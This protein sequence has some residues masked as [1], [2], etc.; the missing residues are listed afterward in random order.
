MNKPIRALHSIHLYINKWREKKGNLNA[1]MTTRRSTTP[2]S[3]IQNHSPM[4]ENGCN[5]FYSVNPACGKTLVRTTLRKCRYSRFPVKVF[6]FFF[7]FFQGSLHHSK[8]NQVVV[9]CRVCI[10]AHWRRN[11]Y[12]I[13]KKKSEKTGSRCKLHFSIG[14][15]QWWRFVRFYVLSESKTL[16]ILLFLN[17]TMWAWFDSF[18]WKQS[19]QEFCYSL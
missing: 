15:Y 18:I 2:K 10:W 3:F 12:Q 11:E 1:S 4:C 5:W 8:C 6:I 9:R 16:K 19:L 7:N 14:I 13:L 17:Y